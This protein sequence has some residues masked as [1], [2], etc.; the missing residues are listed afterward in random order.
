MLD[1]GDTTSFRPGLVIALSTPIKVHHSRI[2]KQTGITV[3]SAVQCHISY[4]LFPPSPEGL[5]ALYTVPQE[6]H[7]VFFLVKFLGTPNAMM[8]VLYSA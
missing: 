2:G 4:A 3:P 5:I 8:K 1:R 7:W 6:A